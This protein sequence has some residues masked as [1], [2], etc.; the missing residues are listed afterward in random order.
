MRVLLSLRRR[1]V[2]FA[3]VWA[4]PVA[5]AVAY[6]LTIKP[7]YRPQATL[8]IRPEMA[9]VSADAS[10]AA[11]A[12]SLPMWTNFY[13]TQEALLR[14]PGLI[15]AVLAAL[16]EAAAREYAGASDP[17]RSFSEHLDIEKT[18][19]SYIMKVGFIDADPGHATEIVNTLVALYL[20]DANRRLREL[21][22]EALEV[23]SKETLPAI[24]QR[25][26]EA[27]KALQGFQAETGF[28]DFEEQYISLVESRRR[29][30]ARLSDI[31][32]REVR[33]RSDVDAF[34]NYGTSGM[35]GLYN[36]AFHTTRALE[37]LA[38]QRAALSSELSRQEE[39][40]KEKHPR[41]I[42]LRKEVASVERQIREA[43][44]GTIEALT[45]NLASL[46]QEEGSLA[47]EATRIE[48]Q[49]GQSRRHLTD[50]R[51]LGAELTTSQELYNSYLKRQNETRA[52]SA[53]GQAGVRVIDPASP[54]REPYRKPRWILHLSV[55]AGMLLGAGAVLLAEQA[56]DRL[57]TVREVEVFLGLD[58]LGEIPKLKDAR[59]GQERPLILNED[60][61]PAEVEAFRALRAQLV[62]RFEDTPSPKVIMVASAEAGEGKST[63]AA[64]LARAL[65][66][67][68]RRVLLLDAELR[69][70]SLKALLGNPGRMGLEELLRGEA[71]L[72]E[73]AQPSRIPGVDVLGADEELLDA[74]DMASS[75]R[76]R[77]AL[78]T[79]R[80]H[81]D[82]IVIDSA[83][84]NAISESALIARRADATILVVRLDKTS[85]TTALAAQKRLA[86]MKVKIL[87]AVVNGTR[88]SGSYHGY[89][90]RRDVSRAEAA[91]LGGGDDLVGIA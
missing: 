39:A 28:A 38:I 88:P 72:H 35:S 44:Q 50:Y 19:S 10:D 42:E 89:Q 30:G 76:F 18:E 23:L 77:L 55:V 40:L 68:D 20:R 33:I 29:V 36:E 54:P 7:S 71:L 66:T 17:V 14:S 70:P 12:A 51:R 85:R 24:R 2:L 15:Q 61:D 21:K 60:S 65:A 8:E 79:A 82:F 32:L 87:G 64:N 56:D 74:S 59:P 69:K 49:M 16:P 90:S 25:F 43:V 37:P 67:Q 22:D 52:T 5:A 31:R 48:E 45:T 73:A 91:I 4:L 34:H 11:Y 63:I 46:V 86:D 3:L 80:E 83:P 1:W 6:S 57:K 75:P 78:K 58:V 26:D 41:L 47:I 27:D 53:A 9:L 62:T 81:Y 84:L 13:R